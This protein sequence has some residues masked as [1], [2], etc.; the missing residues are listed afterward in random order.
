MD[1]NSEQEGRFS[2]A[3]KY[4]AEAATL[5]A[6]ADVLE[7]KNPAHHYEKASEFFRLHAEAEISTV[8]KALD[9]GKK[10]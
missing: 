3:M 6:K 4:R 1:R 2:L 10:R 5:E 9:H 7:N 8:R